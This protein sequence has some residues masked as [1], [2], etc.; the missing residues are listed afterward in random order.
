M[1]SDSVPAS[2]DGRA[3]GR[4]N[5]T[6]D[7]ILTQVGPGT[8]GG[9]LLRRYWQPIALSTEATSMPREIRRLGETLILFR[10]TDGQP[11]LLY[12]RCMHR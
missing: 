4:R 9:E 12:P 10:T 6:S 8:P 7:A 3:Y 2:H 1:N 11:G 5:A